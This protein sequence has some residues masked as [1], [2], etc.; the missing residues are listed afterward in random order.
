MGEVQ[1]QFPNLDSALA[2]SRVEVVSNV[3]VDAIKAALRWVFDELQKQQAANRQSDPA[4]MQKQIQDALSASKE[5]EAAIETL[6]N[7]QVS[8]DSACQQAP[9]PRYYYPRRPAIRQL[10]PDCTQTACYCFHVALCH[11]C[12]P[13][14]VSCTCRSS[15]FRRLT[16]PIRIFRHFS[17]H[18]R[19]LK[20]H[21]W[22]KAA[23]QVCSQHPN[24][25]LGLIL[26][27]LRQL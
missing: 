8:L 24:N 12:L 21:R 1:L 16:K 5:Q 9:G 20:Q 7:Q 25:V 11:V 23:P 14:F 13:K 15:C 19:Q 26:K 3:E 6:K 18:L 22:L 2:V 4:A 27:L 17:K 10:T